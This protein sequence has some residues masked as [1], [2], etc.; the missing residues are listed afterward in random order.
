MP[1]LF[2]TDHNH[3]V[4]LSS[5][6]IVVRDNH[7][8]QHPKIIRQIPLHDVDRV[9]A[10]SSAHIS[11]ML[12]KRLLR[13]HIP[14]SFVSKTGQ[15]IGSFCPVRNGDAADRLRQYI[16][17]SDEA[18]L[19]LQ[20]RELVA[21]KLANS[22]RLLQKV[23]ADRDL[24]HPD[25]FKTACER[26]DQLFVQLTETKTLDEIRGIEGAA[27]AAYF[28]ALA[29]LFPPEFPFQ[30][31]SRRPPRDPVNALLSFTYTL[32]LQE[33][34]TAV[35]L[36]GLDPCLGC[37]HAIAY[38]RPALALDLLEPFRP[39]LCDALVLRI[40]NLKILQPEDFETDEETGGMRMKREALNKFLL[41]FEQRLERLFKEP[42]G[43]RHTCFR[44]CLQAAPHHY[45]TALRTGRAMNVFWAP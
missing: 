27:S 41:Q 12:L 43:N 17:A 37:L 40:T 5:R 36:A 20:A 10:M 22:R 28:R 11:I 45:T 21:A 35:A 4:T 42:G 8:T 7:T 29:Q 14:V 26:I 18:W 24:P 33:L 34:R 13:A 15:L 38:G 16:R 9:V 2:I 31:R 30:G 39:S 44:K 23:S 19:Q 6:H 32:V 25:D 3:R 1:K